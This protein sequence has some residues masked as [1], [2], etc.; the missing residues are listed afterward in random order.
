[1]DEKAGKSLPEIG[2]YDGVRTAME[3]LLRIKRGDE[4]IYVAGSLYL[5]GEVKASLGVLKDD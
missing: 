5:V 1:M 2:T 3:E 4:R